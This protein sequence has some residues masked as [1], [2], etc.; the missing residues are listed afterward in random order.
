[1]RRPATAEWGKLDFTP[2]GG[3]QCP[4]IYFDPILARHAK[5][6][7][8]VKLRYLTRLDGFSQDAAGVRAQVTDMEAG[9]RQTTFAKYLVGCDGP[10][11]VVRD[12][13]GIGRGLAVVANSVNIFFRS[14]ALA[15]FHD[16]GWAR[17]Y[18]LIDHTG[19]WSELIPI[20]G[21]E[22]WRLTVFDDT[23]A[24]AAP[25]AALARMAGG[26]FA[27]DILSV[28]IWERRDFVAD[29]YGR[30]RVL[31]AGDA[32]HE[33]S[34]TG[35]LGMHTGLE[36]AVN[37]AWKLAT[38]IEGW[39]GGGLIASYEEERRP[40]ARHNVT[41]ATATYNAIRG[42]PGVRRDDV[43]RWRADLA[44]MAPT[45]KKKMEYVYEPSSICIPDPD[46]DIA[47]AA[48]PG[49]RAPHAWLGEGRS[50]LDLFGQ[51]FTLLRF[52]DVASGA[53]I[54]AARACGVPLREVAIADGSIAALYGR[55]LVLVR[56]D[57]HVAWR[58][59]ACPDAAAVIDRVRG[60]AVREPGPQLELAGAAP[61]LPEVS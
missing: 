20:D 59:D 19:C 10:G 26:A 13:L 12:V 43:S 5:S 28:T 35:G 55:R 14:S 9:T 46:P 47:P 3:C 15:T 25:Q 39:G 41:L 44:A 18:R 34:P 11:G 48:L 21:C 54:E 23:A 38:M 16:K 58:G 4:Q 1:V 17:I 2:E 60:A 8:G 52:G 49:A 61:A 45:E 22:L 42:I 51:G 7:R 30:G 32:A 29:R 57:G 36:E 53:L 31:I 56:P 50:T 40:I 24:A 27:N 33:C 37:L 6:L